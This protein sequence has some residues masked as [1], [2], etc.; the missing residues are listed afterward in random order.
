M[1][2]YLNNEKEL[3]C[4]V[5]A[6]NQQAFAMLVNTYSAKIYAHVLTYLKNAPLSEEITQDIF[7]QLWKHR[8][9]LPGIENFPGY[10]HVITRNRT[11][12]ELRRKLESFSEASEEDAKEDFLNPLIQLEYRQL[13]DVLLRG[14][15][16]L[17]P[18]RKQVFR[19]SR[20]EGKSYAQIATELGISRGTVNEHMVEAL[21]FLRSYLRV[22]ND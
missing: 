18:R 12:S 5:A 6:G 3:L 16:L 8:T 10:L 19:M 7:L 14:I 17:P 2:E 20:F 13:S 1:Q 9:E 11:I 15:E 21:V 4:Q 22:N